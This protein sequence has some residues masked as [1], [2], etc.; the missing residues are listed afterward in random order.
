MK[1]E[2]N[3]SVYCLRAAQTGPSRER[4]GAATEVELFF[5][6][7]KDKKIKRAKVVN[8]SLSL[9]V[10]QIWQLPLSQSSWY[11]CVP[12]LYSCKYMYLPMQEV[13]N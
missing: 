5:L 10:G 12:Y 11:L 13:L 2:M 6:K 4:R 9:G 8:Y 7:D 1:K 3:E